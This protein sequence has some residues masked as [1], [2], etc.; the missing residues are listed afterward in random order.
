M[1]IRLA[2]LNDSNLA[3]KLLLD[4]HKAC[5]LPFSVS[6][7]WAYGLFKACVTDKDKIAIIKEEGGILLGMVGPSLV[8]PFKQSVELAWWVDPEHRG[9]SLEMIHMYEE[10]AKANGASLIEVK[11]MYKFPETGKIYSRLG[12]EPLEKSWVKKIK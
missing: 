9:G 11:S 4:F 12:Y 5:D 6:T 1:A 3:V 10:W 7:P 2:T 8:G